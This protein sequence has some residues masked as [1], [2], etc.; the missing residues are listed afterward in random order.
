MVILNADGTPHLRKRISTRIGDLLAPFK[1]LPTLTQLNY[2]NPSP[3]S[4]TYYHHH[5]VIFRMKFDEFKAVPAGLDT[6]DLHSLRDKHNLL[7]DTIDRLRDADMAQYV[8]LPQIVVVGDQ[9]SGK[10]SVLEAISRVRFPSKSTLCTRFA[11]E[12][13]LRDDAEG[14]A[15]VEVTIRVHEG[16]TRKDVR[17]RLEKFSRAQTELT[18]LTNIVREATDCMGLDS[19]QNPFSKHTLR[20]K[21]S[22]PSIPELTLVDLPGFYHSSGEGQSIEFQQTVNELAAQYMKQDS[23]IILAVVSAKSDFVMQR[24][25]EEVAKFDPRGERTLGI[26]TK[27]DLLERGGLEDEFLRVL[28]NHKGRS[29]RVL[30]HG[31][32]VLRNRADTDEIDF[33]ARDE[34]ERELFR[35]KPWTQVGEQNKGVQALRKRLSDVLL[36]HVDS[37]LPHVISRIEQLIE[38][39]QQALQ[40]IGEPRS[41]LTHFIRYLDPVATKFARLATQAVGGEEKSS[42][43][44]GQ[45]RPEGDKG[46]AGGGKRNLRAYV[47]DLNRAFIE[48]IRIYGCRRT[49]SWNDPEDRE[50][51]L[52][53]EVSPELREMASWYPT[54]GPV[55][56]TQNEL[57]TMIHGLAMEARGTEL[58]GV[59]NSKIALTLFDDQ[60]KPWESLARQHLD[61]VLEAA[62]LLV[63]EILEHVTGEDQDLR[64]KLDAVFIT[65][66][67]AERK[68]VLE[69]KLREILPY[70]K[71]T[72]FG[73]A[74]E[75][76]FHTGAT[77]RSERRLARQVEH[78]NEQEDVASNIRTALKQD[79]QFAQQVI[80]RVDGRYHQW[81]VERV[82]DYMIQYYVVSPPQLK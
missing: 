73:V 33:D 5:L 57:E 48:V 22:G 26:V 18:D 35:K 49:V 38:E 1:H 62:K 42:D 65:P 64:E 63:A 45:I 74:L 14:A 79:S 29:T 30:K 37:K 61:L 55:V 67:F 50:P 59:Y 72:G 16:E 43:F 25:L 12:L 68:K 3:L 51:W 70:T 46:V 44:F 28:G 41:E 27:P 34:T 8:E 75:D 10:S 58:P 19:V 39:R 23:C 80:N 78:L 52:H 82:I 15:R 66:F 24:V 17:Q 2:L 13:V 40:Q 7:L 69:D 60:A 6:P 71:P 11:T 81:G 31:W 4:L 32:H 77:Q 9:S 47:R 36:K 76:V 53:D 21:I 56:V 20:V 54:E